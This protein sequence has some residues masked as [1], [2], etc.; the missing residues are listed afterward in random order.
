MKKDILTRED[1]E[2][3]MNAFYEKLLKDPSIN[4]I[5]TD[6]AKINIKTH[7]PVICDF[8]ETVIFQKNVYQNNTMKIHMDLHE[9]TPLLKEHFATWLKYFYETV[10]DLF[11]GDNALLA[12]Q[13]AT[14]VATVMQIKLAQKNKEQ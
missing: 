11:E 13:R 8:W 9:Q 2:S 14:S 1:I 4:Y 7:L 3:L 5:F 12:K 10:D 6:V